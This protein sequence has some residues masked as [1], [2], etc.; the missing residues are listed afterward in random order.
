MVISAF[1]VALTFHKHG[2]YNLVKK[3]FLSNLHF[4]HTER[5]VEFL[6]I[7]LFFFSSAVV[8]LNLILLFRT[9]CGACTTNLNKYSKL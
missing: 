6:V 3:L 4:K 8:R 5:F 1:L 2:I 7:F 9:V